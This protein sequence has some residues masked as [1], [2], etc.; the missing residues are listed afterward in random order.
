MSLLHTALRLCSALLAFII[1]LVPRVPDAGAAAW[2]VVPDQSGDFPTIQAAVDASASGDT[3]ILADGIFTGDGNRDVTIYGTAVVIHS[4]SNNPSACIID[5]EAEAPDF[6]HA[7]VIDSV[8]GLG[9]AGDSPV[10]LRGITIM[11]A[12]GHFGGGMVC[13]RSS[14]HIFDCVFDNNFATYGGGIFAS[15]SCSVALTRCV[16]SANEAVGD[17]AVSFYGTDMNV[18]DCVFIGNGG[19]ADGPGALWARGG[20]LNLEGSAFIGNWA[21]YGGAIYLNED[22]TTTISNC[23]FVGNQSQIEDGS[24]LSI[25]WAAVTIIDRSIF[26]FNGPGAA[27]AGCGDS[28]WV[29]CSDFFGNPDGNWSV[30]TD[31][32]EGALE[33]NGNFA[34]DPLFCDS[35]GGAYT[36]ASASPCLPAS[37]SC[38]VLVGAYDQGCNVPSA[39][40]DEGFAIASAACLRAS[41][42]P[43]N[44]RVTISYTLPHEALTTLRIYDVAGRL[45]RSLVD[46]FLTAGPH[47]TAWDGRTASGEAACSGTY[48]AR[49][50]S[51]GTTA[52]IKL[53]LLK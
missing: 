7:F 40:G 35:L 24:A 42:N 50:A 49:L 5:C 48:F 1:C 14:L 26:A 52:S 30:W 17:G 46:A 43:F 23:T 29:G 33:L 31:C 41:P 9:V 13:S 20:T 25:N 3:I 53:I 2:L 45:V 37:N 11:R 32:L 15:E 28:T 38:G 18:L 39:T 36:L 51:D 21:K 6:H 10:V 4:L 12:D 8:G 44:P 16:F 27:I 34:L 47:N 19:M 22:L